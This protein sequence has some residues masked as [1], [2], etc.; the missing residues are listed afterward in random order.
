M[1]CHQEV[2]DQMS[3][4][5]AEQHSTLV[6]HR[7]DQESVSSTCFANSVFVMGVDD[8]TSRIRSVLPEVSTIM[9]LHRLLKKDQLAITGTSVP[10]VWKE[11][12][13]PI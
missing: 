9:E 10:H 1:L 8:L 12:V 5:V 11:K 2:I 6:R 7:Q 13:T 3:D 4:Q